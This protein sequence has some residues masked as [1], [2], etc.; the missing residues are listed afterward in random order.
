MKAGQ[1]FVPEPLFEKLADM[2]PSRGLGKGLAG[3]SDTVLVVLL[4]WVT[5]ETAIEKV[6]VTE[7]AEFV[8]DDSSCAA[9]RLTSSRRSTSSW[10]KNTHRPSTFVGTLVSNSRIPA[11]CG[12]PFDA[13]DTLKTKH[14]S[15]R[16]S[17]VHCDL[18][19]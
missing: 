19:R 7:A 14:A 2:L 3:T 16:N 12:R 18:G 17:D 11:S 5:D 1:L 13:A 6:V 4:A 9:A 15:S 10:L 8:L